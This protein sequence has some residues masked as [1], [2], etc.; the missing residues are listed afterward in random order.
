MNFKKLTDSQNKLLQ[1]KSAYL[2]F[3][4]MQD[5]HNVPNRFNAQLLQQLL[6]QLGKV[7]LLHPL[8]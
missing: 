3:S 6:C 4:S 8:I 5:G 1:I 2:F 7:L